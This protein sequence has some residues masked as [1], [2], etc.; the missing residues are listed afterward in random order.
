MRIFISY[1]RSDSKD[2]AA[3]IADN[4]SQEPGIDHVF[5]DVD[6][7]AHGENFPKRLD[8]E[9]AR[10]DVV[11]AIIGPGWQGS[12]GQD[13]QTRIQSDADFVRR[14]IARALGLGKRV[15]PCLVDGASVPDPASL[16]DDIR[17]LAETNALELRH[18][19]FRTDLDILVD[20]ILLRQ[21][22]RR[23][24]PLG[25]AMGTAWR[26]AAG[27]VAATGLSIMIASMGVA[28][29]KMPL[30]TILGGRVQLALFLLLL[31]T[32]FQYWT[33]RFLR[34]HRL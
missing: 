18:T 23:L 30:E 1:R 31:L 16:P 22:R 11:L 21:R 24:S 20:S 33:F 29:L 3:R 13:G 28:T 17:T 7:I 5:L 4:L 34:R 9:I 14:E 26:F 2:I 25:I 15:I 27:F 12:A 8:T 10:A 32:V 6:A 19:T